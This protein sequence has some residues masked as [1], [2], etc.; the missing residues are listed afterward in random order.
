MLQDSRQ[1][2][3]SPTRL[4]EEIE[5]EIRQWYAGDY[6]ARVCAERILVVIAE[7]KNGI[8]EIRHPVDHL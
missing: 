8:V 5:F 2:G 3:G 7:A 4:V 6:D 1:A